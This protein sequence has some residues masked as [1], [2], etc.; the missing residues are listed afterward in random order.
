MKDLLVK[1]NAAEAA[2]TP[3]LNRLAFTRL[4]EFVAKMHTNLGALARTMSGTIEIGDEAIERADWDTAVN[5]MVMFGDLAK[6]HAEDLYLEVQDVVAA[7][8][9]VSVEEVRAATGQE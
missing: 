8:A 7:A 2:V 5:I 6:A 1:I 4:A 3:S 9:G